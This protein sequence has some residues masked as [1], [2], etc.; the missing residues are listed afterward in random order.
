M[1]NAAATQPAQA[2]VGACEKTGSAAV[3][4]ESGWLESRGPLHSGGSE[5]MKC[6]W[7]TTSRAVCHPPP[8]RVPFTARVPGGGVPGGGAA[9]P[10]PWRRS[11]ARQTGQSVQGARRP[12]AGA[13]KSACAGQPRINVHAQRSTMSRKAHGHCQA[14]P[15]ETTAQP[16]SKS[17]SDCRQQPLP[18]ATGECLQKRILA[19]TIVRS[20]QKWRN[21]FDGL[22][23]RQPPARGSPHRHQRR[24]EA[25]GGIRGVALVRIQPSHPSS[26]RERA[27]QRRGRDSNPRTSF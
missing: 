25:A 4:L 10:H 1:G 16:R 21:G 18:V 23:D 8:T 24:Q 14:P 19:R 26:A 6:D 13:N 22:S 2:C 12:C 3:R 5:E 15:A 20:C 9:G 11:T 17:R 27:S 7:G